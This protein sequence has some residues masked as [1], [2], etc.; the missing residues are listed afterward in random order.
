M[1]HAP[2]RMVR[3]LVGDCRTLLPTL[4][5]GSVHCV[6][7]SPP[8]WGLRDYGA[9]NQI[10]LEATPAAYLE[11]LVGVFHDIWRV[12]RDDGTLW[13][14]LGDGYAG[15]G[16]YAPEA[17]SNQERA[18]GIFHGNT[19]AMSE[20]R[21]KARP[22]HVPAGLKPKDLVGMP[23]RVA[24]ALQADGWFL[25]ADCIWH[26]P[27]PM[28]ESVTDRPTK[29]HEYVFLLTKRARYFYDGDAVR[30]PYSGHCGGEGGVNNKERLKSVRLGA[31]HAPSL[32]NATVNP[33]GRNLR[34]VWTIN[35]APTPDAHFA[36]F[37]P[38]LAARCILAGTSA[39]GACAA[40]GAPRVRQV[41]REAATV[42]SPASR[43]GHG[44]GRND[45]GRSQL[46][47]ATASTVGWA[48]A[49]ACD[50]ATVPCVVLDPFAGTGTT[51]RVAEDLGRDSVLLELNPAYGEL[52]AR[53][54]AQGGLFASRSE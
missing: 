15:G 49:C 14:N 11:A 34:S 26:K 38:Q 2:A 6:V 29:A 39:R 10:G 27:N 43:Y 17:P 50:A 54:T 41:E 52:A 13:L 21:V 18:P 45:G 33:A 24:F 8:Y 42:L 9:A 1:L 51:G 5:A 12:L 20:A 25:R 16:G 4:A 28:P 35:P 37:P 3:L 31:A 23:W 7:T 19:L 48:P 47:G 36:T 53:K 44:A 32:I 40:C 22:G 30:E 46:V